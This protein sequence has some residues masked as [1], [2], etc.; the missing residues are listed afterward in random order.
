M[1][2]ADKETKKDHSPGMNA[3][4]FVVSQKHTSLKSQMEDLDKIL[5]RQSVEIKFWQ[6]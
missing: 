2:A 4:L 3:R 6:K 1:K 5:V